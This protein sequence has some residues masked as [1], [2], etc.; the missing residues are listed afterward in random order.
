MNNKEVFIQLARL[1]IGHYAEGIPADCNWQEIKALAEKY[2]LLISGGSDF[3]GANK[4]HIDL[5]TGTGRMSLPYDTVLKISKKPG[6]DM[7]THSGWD[8]SVVPSAT[9]PAIAKDMAIL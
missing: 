6:Y 7:D 8:I 5:G 2:D 3:H 1:G 9:S 4:P